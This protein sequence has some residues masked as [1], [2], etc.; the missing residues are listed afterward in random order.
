LR[1]GYAHHIQRLMVTGLFAMVFG[2]DPVAVHRWY[3]A[4]Y[5]DAVEWVEMPNVLGMSQF[6]DGGLMSTKP[7]AASGNYIRRMSNYCDACRYDPAGRTGDDACPFTTLYW[8]FLMRHKKRLGENPRMGLQ[9]KNV[10]RIDRRE[11]RAI[12]RAA[13]AVRSRLLGE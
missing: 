7:Y 11:Q 12:R 9:V 6:A 8:E 1:V 3:L 13:E 10:D 5:V 4:V 2:V